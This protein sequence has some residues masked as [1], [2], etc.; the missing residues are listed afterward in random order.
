MSQK[1][2]LF[3]EDRPDQGKGASRRLRQTGK[4]PAI[5]YGGH[6]DPRAIALD[7]NAL[8]HNLE[9]E[10]FFSSI[11]TLTVGDKSQ[12][13]I[14][15]DVQRHPYR[16]IILHADLQR[17]LE[18]EEIRVSVPFHF[19]GENVAPGFKA[20]GVVSRVMN[21]LEISC[22]PK[23]LPEYIDVDVSALELE[24]MLPLSAVKLPEGVQIVGG[25]EMLEQPVVAIHR[26]R[27]EEVEEDEGEGEAEAGGQ[28]SFE[29]E[30]DED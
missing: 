17:I 19:H 9:N 25:E 14:V 24:D 6:R 15:K 18:D 16:N 2:E 8:L 28:E 1:F 26:P 11:L 22:L 12:P 29:P 3:A 10:S 13:C 23:D 20:G 5:L 7:H 4:V 27:L 30:S 21:E